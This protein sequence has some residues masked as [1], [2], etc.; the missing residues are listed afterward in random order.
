MNTLSPLCTI[1]C[2]CDEALQRTKKQLSRARLHAVQTFDL[3]SARLTVQ[4]CSCPLHGPNQCDCQMIV[5]LVY[6]S[7][8]EPATLILHGNDG[9]TWISFAENPS[10]QTDRKMIASLQEALEV[11]A[12]V[13]ISQGW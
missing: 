11:K 9:Q 3:H 7:A 12:P 10:Q 2:S 1:N 8:T 4:D 5:L 6:S 13:A